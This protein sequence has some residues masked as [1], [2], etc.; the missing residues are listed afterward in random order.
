M[1]TSYAVLDS[2][3][4]LAT[5]QAEP[6]TEHAKAL[7]ARLEQEQVQSVAPALLHYE[8]VSV[9]LKWVYRELAVQADASR[10]LD[11]LLRYPITLYF[12]EALLRRGYELA[13]E[14]NRP[15][16]YDSQYMALAERLSCDY[17]TADGRLFNAVNGRFPRIHYLGNWRSEL[18]PE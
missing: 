16:A 11:T 2:G 14:H 18:Q 12:D 6:Y 15:N 9:V 4:L 7:I 5:V 17:W 8:I 10:V 3:I 1:P 13:A